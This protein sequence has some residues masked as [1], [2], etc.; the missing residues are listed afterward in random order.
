[1]SKNHAEWIIILLICILSVLVFS[2]F[3]SFSNQAKWEYKL[4]SPEDYTF[5]KEMNELGD[6]GWELV[7]ARRATV[8]YGSR[9]AFY[10]IILKRRIKKK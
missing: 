1:V 9:D 3:N 4:E 8:S 10:E 2:L 7:S 5:E 6:E